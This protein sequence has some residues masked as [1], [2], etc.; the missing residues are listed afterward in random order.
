MDFTFVDILSFI[1][2]QGIATA[3][4]LFGLGLIIKNTEV[5]ADKYIPLIILAVSLMLTPL[6]LGGYTPDNIV[7]A[8]LVAAAPVM[9]NEIKKQAN[10]E[11]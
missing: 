3:G 8:M 6:V 1:V 9:L 10:K 4:A 7:Q 11:E 5:V 2:E